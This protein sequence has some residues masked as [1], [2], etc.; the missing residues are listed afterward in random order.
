MQ[1]SQSS[2]TCTY[3][4]YEAFMAPLYIVGTGPGAPSHMTEA[5]KQ[6][7]ADSDVIIGYDN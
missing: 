2:S 1:D 7:I 4:R 3:S 6:A 5:A